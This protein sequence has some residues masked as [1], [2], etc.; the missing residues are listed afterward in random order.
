MHAASAGSEIAMVGDLKGFALEFDVRRLADGL[1]VVSLK[2]T[3]PDPAPPPRFTL[4][5]SLPSQDVAGQWATGRHLNKTHAPGLGGRP[6]AG[7]DV[8]ARSTGEQPV[9]QRRPQRARPSRSPTRSTPCSS[10]RGCARR[11]ASSTTR[12]SSSASRTRA[13]PP[14][15]PSCAST[16]AACRTGRPCAAC[17]TGGR[18]SP[19]TRPRPCPSSARLPVYSTWYNYHQS[20]DAAVLLKEVAIAKKMGFD[21]IIVDDGWQTLDS[22]RGYAFTGDWEP[23]R[24]PGHEGLRRRLP[25]ARG[26]GAPLVRGALRGQEREGGGALQGQ[27]AA[28]RRA[29]GR[30][31]A[32][33]PLPRGARVPGRTSTAGP[34]ATGASTASSST[35]S[36]ASSPTTR[37]CSRRPAA[38]T[39]P[40]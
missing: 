36:S 32:R 5:W 1:E 11:T 30:L 27:V 6:A 12:W 26:E 3:S 19:G 18:R 15:A 38:A 31:R 39:S 29:A 28:L 10:A 35:S 17:R 14:G 20:V 21:S 24:M 33:S 34:S 2:L 16:A 23:E 13:S 7:L 9:R 37:P 4:K 25:P 22:G 40:P 8:R